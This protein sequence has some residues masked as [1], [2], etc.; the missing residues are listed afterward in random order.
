ME[1]LQKILILEDNLQVVSRLLSALHE[2]EQS[3]NLYNFDVT[4]LSVYTDV[5]EMINQ[6]GPEYYDIILLD[7]DCK[8][9]GSFHILD[10]DKFNPSKII[11]ISSVPEWNKQAEARGVSHVVDK[12]FD[13]LGSF[14]M[15]VMR[16][17][18]N[19][20]KENSHE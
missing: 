4:L 14:T 3:D 17:I 18:I 19:I 5:E 20:L 16:E 15:I 7:R 12:D 10:I 13:D 6:K 8:M 9:G 1:K 2:V 11:A